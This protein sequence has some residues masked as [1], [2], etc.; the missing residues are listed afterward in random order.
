[1]ARV[2]MKREMRIKFCKV[3][4]TRIAAV[5]HTCGPSAQAK[6]FGLFCIQKTLR[7]GGKLGHACPRRHTLFAVCLQRITRQKTLCGAIHMS[8]KKMGKACLVCLALSVR[9][10][11]SCGKC[12]RLL[13][14]HHRGER[15]TRTRRE[16]CMPPRRRPCR[17]LLRISSPCQ[18]TL[19]WAW[20]GSRGVGF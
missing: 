10:R 9:A 8:Y 1:M 19:H 20:L 12:R 3:A 17:Y 5:R 14:I 4:A 15:H 18:Q 13:P 6:R 11:C 7:E 2:C 16:V